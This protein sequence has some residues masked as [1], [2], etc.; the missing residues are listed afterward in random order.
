[1]RLLTIE[2]YTKDFE[3]KYSIV[4]NKSISKVYDELQSTEIINISNQVS[5]KLDISIYLEVLTYN[6]EYKYDSTYG[7]LH[8]KSSNSEN[9][10]GVRI[11]QV[12]SGTVGTISV[13]SIPNL[14]TEFW[15]EFPF[16]NHEEALKCSQQY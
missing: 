15:L 12:E 1:M 8:Y 7:L 5:G 3:N 6:I 13:Y 16:Y 10:T 11:E 2:D 14:S 9:E 4:Y